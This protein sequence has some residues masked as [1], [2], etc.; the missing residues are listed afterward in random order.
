[1]GASNTGGAAL[2]MHFTAEEMERLTP[3][4]K[5]EEPTG[6]DYYPLPKPGERFPIA[7][8]A[9]AARITPRPAD[10]SSFFQGLL[11]G[12]ASVEA[13]AYQ[14]LAVLGAP[15]LRRVIT[16]GGGARN[17]AWTAIRRRILGVPVTVAEQTE[18]SYGAALLALHGGPP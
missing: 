11:E 7:D 10:G 18:A 1:G 3:Q 16:I 2:L 14:R 9:L 6:L 12:I 15:P 8:P 13:L 17:E 4:L 5:P